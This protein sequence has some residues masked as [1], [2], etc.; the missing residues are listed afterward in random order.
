MK[1]SVE[2]WSHGDRLVGTLYLPEQGTGPFP[3]LVITG[4]WTTVKEQMPSLYAQQMAERG[5]AALVFDFRGWG[6]SDGEPRY[7]EHPERKSRDIEAAVA[8]L[9]ERPEVDSNRLGGLG[10][11]ASSGYMSD[12]ATHS[13][14]IRSYALVA[15]WLHTPEIAEAVYGGAEAVQGLIAQG[16]SAE[17]ADTPQYIEAASTTNEQALMYQAPYYTEP[18]RGLIAEYDNLFNLASWEPW[19]RYDSHRNANNGKPALLVHS[20]AAVIPNGARQYLERKGSDGKM[21]WLDNVTQF[22]FYDQPEPVRL[23]C[24]AVA[25]HFRSTLN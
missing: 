10:I 23:A 4:A 18:E 7:L 11:C 3:G 24:D 19:L 6:A 12:A 17:Q 13:P 8:F 21:L 1:T 20:E 9:A 16:R 5:F 25:A 2:F 22:D 15:P 14:L